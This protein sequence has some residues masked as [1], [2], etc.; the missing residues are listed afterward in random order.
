LHYSICKGL[1]N[2]TTE[3]RYAHR[4]KSVCEHENVTVLLKYSVVVAKRPDIII[5]NKERE[6]IHTNKCGNMYRRKVA[7]KKAEKILCTRVYE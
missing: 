5:K 2:E 4:A 7:Q 1:G 3:K 6:I